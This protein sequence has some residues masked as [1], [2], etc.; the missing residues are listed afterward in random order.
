MDEKEKE[1]VV[2]EQKTQPDIQK[3][4][5]DFEEKI[6]QKFNDFAENYFK[7]QPIKEVE[8]PKKEPIDPNDD[9]YNF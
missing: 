6:N 9:Y 4:I 3:I 7:N 5:K 1:I 2:E 8:E